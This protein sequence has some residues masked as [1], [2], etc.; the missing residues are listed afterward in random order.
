MPIRSEFVRS[1]TL[2]ARSAIL[3]K[4]VTVS[5]ILE[6]GVGK[7]VL[8]IPPRHVRDHAIGREN[9]KFLCG[10]VAG[11]HPGSKHVEI[12][13]PPMKEDEALAVGRKLAM[14]QIVIRPIQRVVSV[15]I[16]LFIIR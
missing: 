6:A 10:K 8:G 1:Y 15:E 16:G 3:K 14:R 7:N 9:E 4:D 12:F 5:F 13:D 11:N 2:E